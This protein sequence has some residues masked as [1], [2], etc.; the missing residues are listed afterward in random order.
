MRDAILA[1][2]GDYLVNAAQ[3]DLRYE[4]GK[5]ALTAHVPIN[6]VFHAS[7]PTQASIASAEDWVEKRVQTLVPA[8]KIKDRL[9]KRAA[10]RARGRARN[11]LN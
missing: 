10:R 5:K 3:G 8:A 7:N 9:S 6:V 1:W 11:Y 4:P 2:V